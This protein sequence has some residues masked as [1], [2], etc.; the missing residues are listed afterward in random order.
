MGHV[1]RLG[2]V[3]ERQ[4]PT[5]KAGEFSLC[6]ICNVVET[7]RS[8]GLQCGKLRVRFP[9]EIYLVLHKV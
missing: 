7:L 2:Y 5:G 3:S 8:K 1:V 9:G 4:S 6:Q